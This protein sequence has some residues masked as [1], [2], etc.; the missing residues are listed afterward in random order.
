MTP[1]PH[2][3]DGYWCTCISLKIFS[4]PGHR[5]KTLVY[6]IDY[7]ER[8][9]DY[10]KFHDPKAKDLVLECGR[11]SHMV[12]VYYFFKNLLLYSQTNSVYK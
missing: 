9:N 5:N 11:I 6:R 3:K 10:R 12:K 4:T 7:Q 8:T 2:P 1:H